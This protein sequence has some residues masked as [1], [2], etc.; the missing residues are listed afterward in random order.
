MSIDVTTSTPT[1]RRQAPP[2]IRNLR[3]PKLKLPPGACDT[4]FHFL[5]PQREFPFN[6]NRHFVPD[7]DHDDSTIADWKQMQSALGLSRGLLVQSMMYYPSY[8]LALH[9]L[10]LMPDRLRGVVSPRAEITD[11]ELDILTKAGVVG[12][13][14]TRPTGAIIDDRV[15]RRTHEFG[16][17][18]HYLCR[19]SD[20]GVWLPRPLL[21]TAI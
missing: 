11:R 14:F 18:M 5:G 7:V 15:V 3:L 8:E 13:R 12:V 21:T 10:C 1:K 4:H 20:R 16:L 6:P 9:G 19:Q 2:P 17:G